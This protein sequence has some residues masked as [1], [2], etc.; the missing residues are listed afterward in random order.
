MRM[1]LLVGLENADKG[2][3]RGW[4]YVT[5]GVRDIVLLVLVAFVVREILNPDLDVV[6]ATGDDDPAGGVLDGAPDRG[7]ER[8]RS[9]PRHA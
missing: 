2:L 3:P 4:W 5:V 8:V 6:R 9:R 7:V 1:L